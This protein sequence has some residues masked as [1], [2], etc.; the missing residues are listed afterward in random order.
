MSIIDSEHCILSTKFSLKIQYTFKFLNLMIP[1]IIY[2][3]YES[4]QNNVSISNERNMTFYVSDITLQLLADKKISII[5]L[6]I[7]KIQEFSLQS[8]HTAII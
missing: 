8:N 3:K 6:F 2:K 1:F 7:G 4:Q 5:S